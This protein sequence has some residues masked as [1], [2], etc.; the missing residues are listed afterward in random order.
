MID[1]ICISLNNACNLK[2]RYCHFREKAASIV[3]APMDVVR[4][5]RNV[6]AYLDR[7]GV[8]VFK[9]GFVGNGEPMLAYDRLRGAVEEIADLLDAGRIAAYTITNGTLVDGAR[10]RFLHGHG[11]NV[12]FSL[13]GPRELHD[14]LRDGSFDRTMAG[15]D[16][17][18]E[19]VGRDPSINATV[20]R[21]TLARQDEVIDFFARFGSRITF[22]RMVGAMG[23]PLGEYNGFLERAGRRLDVRRGGLDCTMYG[24]RCGAGVNNF[25]FAN[26]HVWICG[27]CVDLPPLSRADVDLDEIPLLAA[28]DI[29]RDLCYRESRGKDRR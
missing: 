9:I 1:R 7:H 13:D 10:I 11:V 8:P 3:A 25:F 19:V 26:G 15:I 12:G 14:P 28:E 20:G 21:E 4:I 29:D 24:G 6:R 2:C 27:N 16:L 17:Y 23:I 5:L 22:S 18:R